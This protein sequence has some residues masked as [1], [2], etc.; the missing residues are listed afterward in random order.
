M[1]LKIEVKLPSGLPVAAGV[2][3]LGGVAPPNSAVNSPTLFLGGS[4][5]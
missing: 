4:I 2:A 3:A 1:S 5:G